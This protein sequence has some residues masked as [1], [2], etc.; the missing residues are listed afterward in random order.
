ML[1]LRCK[2]PGAGHLVEKKINQGFLKI[3]Q[4]PATGESQL[5]AGNI[6]ITIEFGQYCYESSSIPAL[7]CS[8]PPSCYA[9]TT[10]PRFHHALPF[11]FRL[12]LRTGLWWL[13]SIGRNSELG[14]HK[15]SVLGF[16]KDNRI[17]SQ[18]LH[19][20]WAGIVNVWKEPGVLAEMVQPVV[21]LV[22]VSSPGN[23]MAM[24]GQFRFTS[25]P[26]TNIIFTFHQQT[27]VVSNS[28]LPN[29]SYFRR[30]TVDLVWI[31]S[32]PCGRF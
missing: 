9:A 22:V 3:C 32:Q 19:I 12:L 6:A 8:G 16:A 10:L 1:S 31:S 17:Q 30:Y 15:T 2:L 28:L 26:P 4:L 5:A 21:L 20:H 14:S 11:C 13:C 29:R 27:G 23:C 25:W 7:L 24:T 18:A